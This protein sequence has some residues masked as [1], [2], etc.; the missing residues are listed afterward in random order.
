MWRA[1]KLL[2]AISCIALPSPA[3]ADTGHPVAVR[4]W[5]QAMVSIENYWNLTVVIDPDG[6]QTGNQHPLVSGDLVL[7]T[8]EHGDHNNIELVGGQPM[9]E[10]GLDDH[11]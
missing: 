1:M 7:I 8:H 11:G 6:E 5:G 9:V 2:A 4:W 3:L 10:R